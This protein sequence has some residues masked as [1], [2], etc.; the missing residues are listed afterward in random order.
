MKPGSAL[1]VMVLVR[2]RAAETHNSAALMT[3]PQPILSLAESLS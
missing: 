3:I 2:S 1:L